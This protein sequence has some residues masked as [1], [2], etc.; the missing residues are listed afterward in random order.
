MNHRYS[1]RS[2]VS[3]YAGTALFAA[4][5]LAIFTT[6][7]YATGDVVIR[8]M[9][10]THGVSDREPIDTTDTFKPSDERAYVFL[11]INNDGPP[12]KLTVRWI[13]NDATHAEVSLN[14][15]TSGSWRT[16]S[17]S[18]LKPGMWSVR[19]MDESGSTLGERDFFVAAEQT[20]EL[21][22]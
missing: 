12:T 8:D 18:N 10:V 17:S 2:L 15:G 6:P 1:L 16:W 20:A 14:V 19:V 21:P 4:A 13:Y 7:T 9:V 11:R 3:R 5:F 22:Q